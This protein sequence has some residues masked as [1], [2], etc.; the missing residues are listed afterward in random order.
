M[1]LQKA[2]DGGGGTTYEAEL[3]RGA[4]E[5]LGVELSLVWC[6]DEREDLEDFS[7]RSRGRSR[8][9]TTVISEVLF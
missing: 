2:I 7:L 4:E 1:L 6:C 3:N 8:S 5:P 9:D